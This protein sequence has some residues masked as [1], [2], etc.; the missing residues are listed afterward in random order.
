MTTIFENGSIYTPQEMIENGVVIVDDHGKIAYVG[1]K[2]NA[3]LTEG[4]HINLAGR[5]LAPGLIDIHVHGGNG[6]TFGDS[7]DLEKDLVK[8]AEWVKTRGV[9]G[10]LLT[11]AAPNPDQLDEMI[12]TYVNIFPGFD[13]GAE[14]L[15]LHLEGPFL[16]LEKKGAFNPAWLRPPNTPEMEKHFK[17]GQGWIKQI[18]LAPEN[19]GAPEVAALCRRSDVVAA[20]GHTNTDY[21]TASEALRGDFTHVTHTFNAQRG[22]DHRAPGVFGAIL[23]SDKVTTELI[24]DTIHVHPGAMKILVRCVGPDRVVAITDAMAGAGLADG[25]Y[26]LV[27]HD[28]TVKDGRATLANGTLA[29]GVSTLNQCVDNLHRLVGVPL[30]QALQMASLNPARVIGEDDRIGSIEAGKDANLIVIDEKV[31]VHLTMIQGKVVYQ[32]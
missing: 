31:N 20:L 6:V 8:Y 4:Q 22:F 21:E 11:I 13:Q 7:E 5:I 32:Q 30:N 16:T 17:L 1:S 19:P 2:Q 15:G 14:P 28:V 25:S 3:P 27:G 12:T 9:T 29:G 26:H 10:F 24:A 18:T 23:A